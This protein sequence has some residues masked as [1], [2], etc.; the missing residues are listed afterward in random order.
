M[1]TTAFQTRR[2]AVDSSDY[3]AAVA[4]AFSE[5]QEQRRF[6]VPAD[7]ASD[8]AG[9]TS[10]EDHFA[11]LQALNGDLVREPAP[12]PVVGISPIL[13]P[14]QAAIGKTISKYVDRAQ[15]ARNARRR[16]QAL[17]EYEEIGQRWLAGERP[18]SD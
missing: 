9:L 12:T 15:N 11:L 6:P 13:P 8:H 3:A 16:R 14:D 17:A 1:K 18:L 7:P 10:A 4:T 2:Y 5:S